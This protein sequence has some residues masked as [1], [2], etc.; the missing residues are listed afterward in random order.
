MS[1]KLMQQDGRQ[2]R[3]QVDYSKEIGPMGED[4]R[5]KADHNPTNGA[6]RANQPGASQVQSSTA[7]VC[8][9]VGISSG[10]LFR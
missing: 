4:E 9:G 2:G 8:D 7:R 1:Q 3:L 6:E 5:V 10:S